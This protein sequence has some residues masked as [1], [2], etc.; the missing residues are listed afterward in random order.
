MA[1]QQVLKNPLLKRVAGQNLKD[2][3]RDASF[4]V[5]V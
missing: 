4:N 1:A 5:H 3:R 2:C